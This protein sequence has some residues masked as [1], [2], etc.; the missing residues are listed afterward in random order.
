MIGA[1][2]SLRRARLWADRRGA[3]AVEFAAVLAP[4]MILIFGVFEY[5]RLLW[6][7]EALQATATAGAR[8]MGMSSTSCASGGTYNSGNTDTYLES[9]ATNWG[10]TLTSTNITLNNN[11]TCAG[12]SAANGFSSVT[13]TYTFQSIVPSLITS[14]NTSPVLTSTACF[15]N[16]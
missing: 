12:V 1:L 2:A 13:I 15:P 14:L 16:Y 11:T 6:T 3:A 8:C 5:G 9:Q 4:L 10:I 7:R